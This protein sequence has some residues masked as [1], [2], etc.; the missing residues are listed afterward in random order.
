MN[1]VYFDC[2]F[3]EKKLLTV[4]TVVYNNVELIR[5][6]IENVI[7]KKCNFVEYIVVDGGSDDGTVDIIKEYDSKIDVWV[8]EADKG[9]Y[10]AMNKAVKLSSSE[11]IIFINAGDLFS[12]RFQFDDVICYGALDKTVFY[13]DCFVNFDNVYLLNSVADSKNFWWKKTTPCHQAIFIPRLFLKNNPFSLELK[14]Y[15][16]ALVM[17][18]A[19]SSFSL[20]KIDYPISIFLIGGLS[21][22]SPSLREYISK[23]REY[24]IVYDK[25]E[26]FYEIFKWTIHYFLKKLIGLNN[27]IYLTRSRK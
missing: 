13:S 9:L 8:S 5:S 26:S 6:T 14:V 25:N 22:V 20:I 27:Y 10:D 2:S 4:V 18:K 17:R 12:S 15:S 21:S 11:S 24:C 7:N 16:D 23:Y 19:L 3:P 1:E